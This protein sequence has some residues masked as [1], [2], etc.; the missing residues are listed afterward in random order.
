MSGTSTAP[1][2]RAAA[3]K[4]AGKTTSE[5][6]QFYQRGSL[7]E[8]RRRARPSR[9]FHNITALHN[10]TAVCFRCLAE[11]ARVLKNVGQFG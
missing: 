11:P 2:Q 7:P 3:E 4:D 5:S 9:H 1:D 10:L 6:L 8:L